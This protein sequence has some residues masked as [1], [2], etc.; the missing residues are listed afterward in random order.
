[1]KLKPPND[2]A[3]TFNGVRVTQAGIEVEGADA[4]ALIA[5]GWKKIT[6]PD[7]PKPKPTPK[8]TAQSEESE[9]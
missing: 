1:M 4:E 6:S 8:P 2:T 7:T 5:A 9:D 3:T